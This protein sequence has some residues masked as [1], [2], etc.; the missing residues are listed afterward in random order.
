MKDWFTVEPDVIRLMNKHFTHGRGGQRIQYITRHH[1]AG[2]GTTN[3]V[4]NWW[5]TRQ[6]SA[7]YVVENSGRIGQLVWDRD[8][9][10]SNANP[11]SNQRSIAIEHSNSTGRLHGSD[12]FPSW[13]INDTVIREG[14]RLAGALC[15]FYK[16]GRPNFGT[17]IRDHRQFYGTSCPHHLA[18]GGRYHATWMRIAQEHYDWMVANPGGQPPKQESKDVLDMDEARLREIIREE[19]FRVSRDYVGPGLSDTKDIRQQLTGGRDMI[20]GDLKASYPGWD[21]KR[22]VE[23][24]REKKFQGLTVTEMCAV[25]IGGTDD[26]LAAARAAANPKES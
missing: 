6:A 24:A 7:H 23:S 5:Q 12:N 25:A 9:A 13:Q 3:D 19:T 4:W 14:A 21:I 20:P 16:L 17:N 15:W 10:W 11:L 1:L 18:A 26:D 22:L 2:I 8:T